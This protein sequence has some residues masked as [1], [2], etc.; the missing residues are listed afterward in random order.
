MPFFG[1]LPTISQE[2]AFR[3]KRLG[4]C[5]GSGFRGHFGGMSA[6]RVLRSILW[7]LAPPSHQ[8]FQECGKPSRVG[9]RDR[10]PC[11]AFCALGRLF[12]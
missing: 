12:P 6:G 9:L 8:P 2:R 3:N 1:D 11:A 10:S 4:G 5:Q 7:S